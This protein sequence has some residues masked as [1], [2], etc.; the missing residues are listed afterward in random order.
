MFLQIKQILL[1]ALWL[2]SCDTG[3]LTLVANIPNHLKEVSAT[4]ITS[5]SDLIWMVEDAGNDNHLYG[6]DE[7]GNIKKDLTVLNSVNRDWED[8]TSDK[9]G[10]LYI[11]DFGNNSRKRKKFTI[12]KIL[13][14]ESANGI[15]SAEKI[16]FELPKGV[17]S[18]DFEAFFIYE[19]SFYIFSKE[20]KNCVML[21]VPDKIGSHT[22]AL[23]TEFNLEGKHNLVTSADI[24]DDG[25][26]V[27]LLNHDKVWKLTHFKT[28]NFFDGTIESFS[29]GHTSQ[30]EG[31]CFKNNSTLYLTDESNGAEGSNIYAFKL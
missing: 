21:K 22:A 15:I 6:L 8:L 3:E 2:I 30:K 18:K 17:K 11:G 31:V 5:K 23:V 12:Y 7:N 10:N 27:V 16:N 1:N 4:E 20:S 9:N 26:T 13:N 14:P 25:R 24:S 19:D 28:D 29:F